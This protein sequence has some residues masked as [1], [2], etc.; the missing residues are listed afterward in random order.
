MRPADLNMLGVTPRACRIVMVDSAVDAEVMRQEQV[1]G[2]FS[3]NLATD[4][5]AEQ[6]FVSALWSSR[7]AVGTLPSWMPVAVGTIH[8]RE[9][10]FTI[11]LSHTSTTIA[12]VAERPGTQP[13]RSAAA[14]K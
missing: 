9:Q 5:L 6:R 14:T 2:H 7:P 11:A 1:I 13:Y 8:G 4:G 3:S 10:R 12:A